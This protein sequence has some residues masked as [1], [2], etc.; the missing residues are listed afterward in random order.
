MKTILDRLFVMLFTALITVVIG[1]LIMLLR[2]NSA[3]PAEY[4]LER[5]ERRLENAKNSRDIDSGYIV[6]QMR[7]VGSI[8]SINRFR[9]VVISLLLLGH[10]FVTKKILGADKKYNMHAAIDWLGDGAKRPIIIR[11]HKLLFSLANIICWGV[12]LGMIIFALSRSTL[13]W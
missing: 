12:S 9:Y 6:K 11:L 5:I 3:I 8:Q 1:S 2:Y 10:I 13:I 7:E 4:P